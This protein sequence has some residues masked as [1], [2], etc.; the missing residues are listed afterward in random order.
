MFGAFLDAYYEFLEQQGQ[1][2]ALSREL[3]PGVIDVDYTSAQF[4]EHFK[5]NFLDSF[6]G[7]F[8]AGTERTIKS[9]LDFY[10]LKG[11]PKA[12]ELM[13]QLL[14]NEA[15]TVAYPID[16]VMRPSNANYHRPK[17]IEVYAPSLTKLIGLDGQ[18]IVGGSTGAKAFVESV[19]TKLINNVKVHVIYLSNVRGEFTRGEILA[20]SADGIQDDM[21]SITGSLSKVDVTL[22]GRGFSV[23]DIFK[24][25]ADNGKQGK[26][27]VSKTD[28]ATGLIE[29]KFSN[30]GFG[31]TQNTS[32][33]TIDVNDQNLK[34]TNK[35]NEATTYANTTHPTAFDWHEKRIDSA[36]FL[37]WETVEQ[38]V[39]QVGYTSSAA[40][41]TYLEQ[42][43]SANA[44][45]TPLVQGRT[46][47]A[48]GNTVVANGY[49]VSTSINGSN[50]TLKIAP[51]PGSFGD[52]R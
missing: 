15:A 1:S 9:I 33:T 23:G 17:Y 30:G 12:V 35:L 36:E 24:V 11:S 31:F 16:Q 6:P 42:A 19:V 48:T 45:A 40:L 41:G 4:L 34:T 14:Y 7:E 51:T 2:L 52:A 46:S 20:K 21:P 37:R 25:T 29:F 22:G 49:V 32:F 47:S 27:R 38:H 28:N 43:I 26:L 5:L 50:A 18:E 44:D 39:E 3:M 8:K 13:F 10:N